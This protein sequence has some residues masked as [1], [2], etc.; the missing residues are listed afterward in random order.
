MK[1]IKIFWLW[2]TKYRIPYLVNKY[3]RSVELDTNGIEFINYCAKV[4][5]EEYEPVSYKEFTLEKMLNKMMEKFNCS[6]REAAIKTYLFFL[7]YL[8][9]SYKDFKNQIK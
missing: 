3:I 7:T 8:P 6:R 9:V 4:I 2:L 1:N 5:T